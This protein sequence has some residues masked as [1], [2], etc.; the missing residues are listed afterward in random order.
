MV[1]HRHRCLIRVCDHSRCIARQ[2]I[3]STLAADQT[4]VHSSSRLRGS[5]APGHNEYNLNNHTI[6][7]AS[8]H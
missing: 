6:V 7:E 8:L 1:A 5:H 2:K 4:T 3:V